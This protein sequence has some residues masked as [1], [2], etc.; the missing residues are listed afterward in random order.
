VIAGVATAAL[1]FGAG[2][3]FRRVVLPWYR[4]LIYRGLDIA[5]EWEI[6]NT[7]SQRATV[8]L[9]QHADRLK[10]RCTFVRSRPTVHAFEDVRTMSVSGSVQDKL[11]ELSFRYENRSRI[12][13]GVFLLEIAGDGRMMRGQ[14]AMWS[15][16]TNRIV[17]HDCFFSRPGFTHHEIETMRR[18]AEDIE[19][20]NQGELELSEFGALGGVRSRGENDEQ[21]GE[22]DEKPKEQPENK[23]D[24][25]AHQD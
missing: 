7:S 25:S 19:G 15:V 10:G 4:E 21:T 1:L 14:Q 16:T 17:S 2:Q 11:V 5:G 22:A 9:E 18:G 24:E 13:A 12:G 20:L 6:T 23:P 8:T 3:I